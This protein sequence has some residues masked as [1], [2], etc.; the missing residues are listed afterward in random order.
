VWLFGYAGMLAGGLLAVA[1]APRLGW[2]STLLLA[3]A[4][5]TAVLVAGWLRARQPRRP[6][7]AVLVGRPQSGSRHPEPEGVRAGAAAPQHG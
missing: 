4:G 6:I 1:A 7:L 5:G 3:C 2:M